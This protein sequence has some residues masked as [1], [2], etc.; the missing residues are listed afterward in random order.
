MKILV[1][2]LMTFAFHYG[3]AQ[4]VLSKMEGN[5][6]GQGMLFNKPASFQMKWETAINNSFYRLLFKNQIDGSNQVFSAEAMYRIEDDA[7]ATGWWFDIRK[8]FLSIT[9]T[10]DQDQLTSIWQNSSEKGKTVYQLTS[11]STMVVTDFV[12]KND[13]W[14]QFGNVEYNRDN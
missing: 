1:I 7:S 5:W 11:E 3:N 13:Q 8:Y 6:N 4:T 10:M 9:S 12:W 2:L 14:V